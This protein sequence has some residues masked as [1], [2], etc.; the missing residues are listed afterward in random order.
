MSDD[1]TLGEGRANATFEEPDF[2][3]LAAHDE[4]DEDAG[5]RLAGGTARSV[6]EHVARSIVD[7]PDAVVVEVEE[8]RGGLRLSL[9]VAPSDMGRIIGK[10]GRVAQAMRALVRAA[11]SREGT[12]ATVDIVD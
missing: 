1:A 2:S 5:N 11:A 8:A 10:R 9:H 4:L 6:L 7:E 12:D 3:G